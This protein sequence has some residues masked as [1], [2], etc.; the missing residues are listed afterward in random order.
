MT[1]VVL[2]NNVDHADLR[3]RTGHGAEFGDDLNQVQVLP[4]EFEDMQR[5]YPIVFRKDDGVCRAFALFGFDRREN[6]FLGEGT[7]RARHV[8][9]MQRRGPF[10]IGAGGAGQGTEPV[11]HVDLDHPRVSRQEG[12]PL[13]LPH[14]GNAPMLE[15]MAE[16]LRTIHEGV[17]A[18][19]ALT[20]ALDAAGVLEPVVLEAEVRDGRRYRVAD[21]F[22]IGREALA[23][24]DAATLHSL[25]QDGHL[26]LAVLAAASLGNLA[27]L[28]AMKRDKDAAA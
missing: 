6:L 25:N 22:T 17:A 23:R 10:S 18:T 16:A 13:F 12:E 5:E 24:L 26:P 1:K 3:V 15:R 20:S 19:A 14:G 8:P 28:A 2:L 9:A 4:A 11:I 7:W 27:K 21:V